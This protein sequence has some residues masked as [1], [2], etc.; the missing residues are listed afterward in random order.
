MFDPNNDDD[1]DDDDN[2]DDDND[3]DEDSPSGRDYCMLYRYD[4]AIR[5][6]IIITH[7]HHVSTVFPE[8]GERVHSCFVVLRS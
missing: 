2:D 4:N 8:R 7:C 3:D 5:G 1:N 6:I